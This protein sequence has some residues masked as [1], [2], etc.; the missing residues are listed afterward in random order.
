MPKPPQSIL[1]RWGTWLQATFHYFKYFSAKEVCSLQNPSLPLLVE[2]PQLVED[3]HL[4][5]P[6]VS[7]ATNK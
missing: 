7:D 3:V 2:S 1:A 5:Q 6:A 4:Y